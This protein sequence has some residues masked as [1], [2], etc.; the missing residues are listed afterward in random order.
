[1][2]LGRSAVGPLGPARRGLQPSAGATPAP[3]TPSRS[4]IGLRALKRDGPPSKRAPIRSCTG[5]FSDRASRVLIRKVIVGTRTESRTPGHRV[6]PRLYIVVRA[7]EGETGV[8]GSPLSTFR[9]P[10][11]PAR[12][13][14]VR[15][16][17]GGV[18]TRYPS[19]CAKRHLYSAHARGESTPYARCQASRRARIARA[20]EGTRPVSGI[21]VPA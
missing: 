1:M 20:P 6:R 13:T 11:R 14:R 18:A 4:C 9:F 7:R 2:G 21:Q 12:A 16:R 19:A 15:T 5:P 3:G 10:T 8:D 17:R